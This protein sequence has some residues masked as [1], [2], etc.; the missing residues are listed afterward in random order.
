MAQLTPPMNTSNGREF[1]LIGILFVLFLLFVTWA[2]AGQ[3][4]V[5]LQIVPPSGGSSVGRTQVPGASARPLPQPAQAPAPAPPPEARPTLEPTDDPPPRNATDERGVFYDEQGVAV[6]GLV[7]DSSG[8]HNVPPGRLVRI[9]GPNG[10]L[11]EVL[12][13]GKIKKVP[14]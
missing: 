11:Y 4:A 6:T 9:G 2:Y 5:A 8:V 1:A 13:G 12:L 3:W 10:E 7:A 14:E